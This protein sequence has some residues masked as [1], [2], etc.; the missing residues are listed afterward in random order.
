[1]CLISISS[2][3]VLEKTQCFSVW[4]QTLWKEDDCKNVSKEVEVRNELENVALSISLSVLIRSLNCV[5]ACPWPLHLVSSCWKEN[6]SSRNCWKYNRKTGWFEFLFWKLF[7]SSSVVWLASYSCEELD[8]KDLELEWRLAQGADSG[9]SAFW[10]FHLVAV[11]FD[12][13]QTSVYFKSFPCF[14]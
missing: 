11:T 6:N 1:M 9:E 4:A 5:L 3:S 2:L 12:C 14:Q 7:C 13:K 10:D 8:L